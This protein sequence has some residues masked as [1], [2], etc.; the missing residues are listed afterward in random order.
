[1]N[2]HQGFF[3]M[4]MDSMMTVQ[5]RNRLE[6][7]LSCSLPPTVAFEYPTV[8]SLTDFIADDVIKLDGRTGAPVAPLRKE[9]EPISEVEQEELSEQE[10]V[11][12]L[13]R[14]LEQIR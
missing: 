3:K 12:L 4:G 8:E 11:D 6:T 1:V 10:L 13:T 9:T 7:S 5:L 14:K 2:L